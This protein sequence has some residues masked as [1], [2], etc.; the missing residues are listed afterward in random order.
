MTKTDAFDELLNTRIGEYVIEEC[1]D[2]GGQA[3]VFKAH[4]QQLGNLCALKIFGLLDSVGQSLEA[5]LRDAQRQ[6]QVQHSAVVRVYPP[7]IE[8]V[9]VRG[10]SRRILYVPM[11]Y[12][13]LGSCAHTPPFAG[14]QLLESDLNAMINLL[15]GLSYIHKAELL[16]N[17]IKPA[18]ILKFHSRSFGHEHD[19]LRIT[20][21]GIAKTKL[22]L[23][24]PG[25]E[26]S[27]FTPPFMAPEQLDH[28]HTEKSDIYSMGATLF[29]MLTGQNPID[30]ADDDA[31]N[32]LA[33]QRAHK[34]APRPDATTVNPLCPPRLALL[35][36]RMMSVDPR[37][38]PDIGTC[39]AELEKISDLLHGQIFEFRTP[40]PPVAAALAARTFP[41][42]ARPGFR[43]IFRPQVHAASRSTLY[44]VRMK[45][46]PPVF[47]QYQ[48]LIRMVAQ[49]FFDSFS[50]Y[51]TWGSY[52]VNIMIWTT[53]AEI[54][55]LSEALET[56]FPGSEPHVF[57]AS[58]VQHF[59][60]DEYPPAEEPSDVLALAIQ[61]GIQIP[62]LDNRGYLASHYPDDMPERSVRAV[63]YVEA[64]DD[65][66]PH[67]FGAI[68]AHIR[69]RLLALWRSHRQEFRRMTIIELAPDVAAGARHTAATAVIV[70]YVATEYR[71]LSQVP[72]NIIE[73]MGENAVRTV[74]CLETRRVTIQ[75]DKL[76][77]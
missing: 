73:S 47:T 1:I 44:V 48:R 35:I 24:L 52:D 53:G 42:L 66:N 12:S 17:D 31:G 19:E 43:G 62:G 39:I 76:L 20:D 64:A 15:D 22:T 70:D 16:H 69:N 26:L 38:R 60:E 57:A 40:P 9:E 30:V 58:M 55:K 21:F 29:H 56:Q 34:S 71:Y 77:L 67:L 33:W 8:E 50:M 32:V 65:L 11:D 23:V 75:S 5:G 61:E 2:A 54:T 18:N 28:E 63:T 49:Q 13:E 36:M 59:H 41:L 46:K 27:G 10:R 51:E 7:A 3:V 37:L 6:S 45:V 4:S 68:G 14:R 25:D 74:T 72:T